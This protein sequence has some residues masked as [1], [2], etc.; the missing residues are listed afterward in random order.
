MKNTMRTYLSE[1]KQ[2][3]SAT[4]FRFM[5]ITCGER[6]VRDGSGKPFSVMLSEVEA[7]AE[8]AWSEQPDPTLWEGH[9]LTLQ[10]GLSPIHHFKRTPCLS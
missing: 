4:S 2:I 1:P 10:S 3:V 8:K 5:S 9:A 6:C 7:L